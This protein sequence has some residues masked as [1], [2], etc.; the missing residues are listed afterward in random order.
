MACSSS[1][2]PV[3]TIIDSCAAPTHVEFVTSVCAS[4]DSSTIGS[5]TQFQLCSVPEPGEFVLVACTSGSISS[6]GSGDAVI[7][8]CVAGEHDIMNALEIEGDTLP[9][10]Q[11]SFVVGLQNSKIMQFRDIHLYSGTQ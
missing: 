4:G 11:L 7:R 2:R 5:G 9:A 10:V 1:S 3:Q 8:P 6:V